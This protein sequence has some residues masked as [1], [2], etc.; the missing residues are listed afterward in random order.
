MKYTLDL[1]PLRQCRLAL[2][3]TLKAR[4]SLVD[5][6]KLHSTVCMKK[7]VTV[8]SRICATEQELISSP[9]FDPS[10]SDKDKCIMTFRNSK[11][12]SVPAPA[13]A[14]PAPNGNAMTKEE[15]HDLEFSESAKAGAVNQSISR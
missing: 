5:V 10:A 7:M 15:W 4:I 13:P 9:M 8:V 6:A 11:D 3:D 2:Q 1:V 12:S 14:A